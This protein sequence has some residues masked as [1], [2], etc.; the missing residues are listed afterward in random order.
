MVIDRSVVIVNYEF[1]LAIADHL[2]ASVVTD[3]LEDEGTPAGPSFEEFRVV[4]DFPELHDQIHQILHFGLALEHFKEL[5]YRQFA[6]NLVVQ[7]FLPLGHLAI[8]LNFVLL[9]YFVL[10]VLLDPSQH[11][12]LENRVKS[13]KLV[14]VQLF[15]VH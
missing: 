15:L 13:L 11:E 7:F 3:V 2:M 10:H 6:L 9:P 8:H 12:W 14:L 5:L 4:A 1:H